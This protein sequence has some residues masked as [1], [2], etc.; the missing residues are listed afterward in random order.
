MK[1]YV[2]VGTS[3][4]F[5]DGTSD[6]FDREYYLKYEDAKQAFERMISDFKSSERYNS[7][8]EEYRSRDEDYCSLSDYIEY[9]FYINEIEIKE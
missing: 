9:E 6:Y 1:A 5:E 8:F 2:V 7:S 3:Y 4:Y